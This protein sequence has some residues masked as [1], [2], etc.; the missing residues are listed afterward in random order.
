MG[1]DDA[2]WT[3]FLDRS[4]LARVPGHRFESIAKALATKHP[5]RSSA[6]A[7]I[8]LQPRLPA[9]AG[10]DPL[11]PVYVDRLLGLGLLQVAD[12]LRVLLTTS[13]LHRAGETADPAAKSAEKQNGEISAGHTPPELEEVLIFRVSHYLRRD[14]RAGSRNECLA[15]LKATAGWMSS[16]VTSTARD[17]MM[18]DMDGGTAH[19]LPESLAGNISN[20][21]ID[22]ITASFDILSNATFRNEPRQTLFL[23]RSFLVNKV[24]LLLTS[25]AAS[26]FPPITAEFCL[27]QALNHV[28]PQAFPSFSSVFDADGDLFSDVRQEFLFA[29]CLHGLIPQANIESLLGE[30]PMQ[31]LPA[32][33]RYS[34]AQLVSQCTTDIERIE[35]LLGELEGLDGNAGAVAG[36][37]TEVIHTLCASKETMTLKSVCISLASKPKALDVMALFNSPSIILQPV[38]LLLDSWRDEEDQGEYQPVYEEFGCILLLVLAFV[39]RYDLTPHDLGT[40]GD[41]SFVARLIGQGYISDGLGSLTADQSKHLGGWIRALYD[42]DNGISDDLMSS[43]RP[44]DFYILVPTLFSQSV[45]ACQTNV[46]EVETLRGGLE[47]LLEAFL[48][49]SLICAMTWLTNHLWEAHEDV[50][51]VMQVLQALVKPNSISGEAQTMHQTVLSAVGKPLE[52]SLRELRRREP[53]RSDIDPILQALSPHLSFKRTAASRHS[54]LEAWTATQGGGLAAS[55]RHTFQSL[56]L[57]SQN[58]SLNMTPASYTH[59]QLLAAVQM[60]GAKSVMQTLL[61]ELKLQ[62]QNGS[63]DL[64]LDIATAL[65]CAPTVGELPQFSS[66]ADPTGSRHLPAK[67]RLTLRNALRMESDDAPNMTSTD[68]LRAETVTRLHRRVEA[69]MADVGPVVSADMMQELDAA[70][71]AAV[72]AGDADGVGISMDLGGPAGDIDDVLGEAAVGL[73]SVDAD[74]GLAGM[75]LS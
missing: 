5:V 46:M 68:L 63:G 25:L 34:K 51:I 54:E 47:Y 67:G 44:H 64:A 32:G 65:V 61:D 62:T 37:I 16:L 39:H 27:T 56:V 57:W 20:L 8:L 12:L 21:T 52:H 22:L 71:A 58:P 66:P 73:M 35:G 45:T 40:T 29:C 3:A 15:T 26:M 60:L 72:A 53:S 13:R 33:G 49:P 4:F 18:Q 23:F 36:A 38:C 2:R 55:L 48:L 70:A 43:C 24:P 42:A 75:D 74:G 41:Q 59:R 11:V 31:E 1:A 69:Q 28:D 7:S 17:E 30:V 6:I 19:V 50:N 14:Q 10:F 9:T